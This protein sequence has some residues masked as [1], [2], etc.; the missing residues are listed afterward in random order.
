LGDPYPVQPK[1]RDH[2]D[3]KNKNAKTDI[4]CVH[5]KNLPPTPQRGKAKVHGNSGLSS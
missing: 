4:N 3:Q 5:E 2:R 1:D